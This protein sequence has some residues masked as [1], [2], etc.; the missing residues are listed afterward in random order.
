[1]I[2]L[3][4]SKLHFND[5]PSSIVDVRANNET[6]FPAVLAVLNSDNVAGSNSLFI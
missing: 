3:L 2:H 1:M 4:R 5:L 6:L